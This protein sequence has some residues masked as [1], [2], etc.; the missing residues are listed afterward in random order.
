MSFSLALRSSRLSWLL[1]ATII[2]SWIVVAFA[3]DQS[4]L[5]VQNSRHLLK[6][7]AINGALFEAG[8]WWRLFVSQ[9]LH[10]HAPH[11]LFN[12]LAVLAIGALIENSVGRWWLAFVYLVGGSIGQLAGVAFHPSLVSS[13]ASQA[14]MALCGAALATCRTRVAYVIVVP[15]LVIQLA[16]DLN[17]AGTIKAGH[18][19]GFVAGVLLGG[20]VVLVFRRKVAAR[21]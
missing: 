3:L 1:F 14:L 12:A 2:A 6:F 15:I 9:F 18:G 11:M 8:E 16:L 17:A 4:M 19:W 7:G 10:V 21:L 13:G 20:A 5:A